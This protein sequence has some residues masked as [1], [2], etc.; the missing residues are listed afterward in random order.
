MASE[1][2]RDVAVSHLWL[3]ERLSGDRIDPAELWGRL[4]HARSRG[5]GWLDAQVMT[6]HME[7]LGAREIPREEFLRR[8]RQT[9][10]SG[11]RLFE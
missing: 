2:R 3:E 1:I 8:L 9:Q 5:S 11:L 7:A 10:G 4:D 6:P